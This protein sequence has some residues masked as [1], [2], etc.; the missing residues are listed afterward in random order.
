MVNDKSIWEKELS[1]VYIQHQVF[2]GVGT[3]V[4]SLTVEPPKKKL[5]LS[6]LNK[7]DTFSSTMCPS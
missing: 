6:T 4:V 1:S 2:A 5:L 3:G 7:T